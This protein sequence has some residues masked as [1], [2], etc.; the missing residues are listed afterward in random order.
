MHFVSDVL[1]LFST[2]SR[3]RAKS[4][5]SCDLDFSLASIIYQLC[6]LAVSPLL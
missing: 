4:K 6:D 3:P 2:Q 5:E 1:V